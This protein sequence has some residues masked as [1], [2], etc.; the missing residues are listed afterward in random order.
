MKLTTP[1]NKLLKISLISAVCIMTS[2]SYADG[3]KDLDIFLQQKNNAISADFA[4]TIYGKKKNK[5]SSGNMHISRPN[6]FRWQYVGD[7]QLMISDGKHMYIYD[8]PLQQVTQKKLDGTLGK[9][10]ALLLAGG[11]D[12][13]KNYTVKALPDSDGLEWVELLPKNVQD[14]NG[15]KKVEMAF[16]KSDQTL[17][18]MKFTDSF[19]N[20]SRID[21]T[22]VKYGV[23][24]SANEFKFTPPAGVDVLKADN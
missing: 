22:N 14:N 6:K 13:K 18:A 20:K 15:F 16:K 24:F 21:F 12:V 3:V 8:K 11:N 19:D 7:E 10:P 9:S 23:S 2:I 4:Q 1:T 17:S 5:T